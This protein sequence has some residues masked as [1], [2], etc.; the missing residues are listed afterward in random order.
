MVTIKRNQ[1]ITVENNSFAYLENPLNVILL[2]ESDA[3]L[4]CKLSLS[5]DLHARYGFPDA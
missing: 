1:R 2:S 4:E 3:R 5:K